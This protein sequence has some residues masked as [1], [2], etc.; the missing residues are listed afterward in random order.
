[1][2]GKQTKQTGRSRRVLKTALMCSALGASATLAGA[3]T[4]ARR[5]LRMPRRR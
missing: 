5:L 3:A 2:G 1:M 4:A